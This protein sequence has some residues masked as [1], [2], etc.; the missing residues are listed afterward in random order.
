M[1]YYRPRPSEVKGCIHCGISFETNHKRAVYC[2]E[3][4]RQLAYQARH[5][6]DQ[7][8]PRKAKGDLDLSMQNVGVSAAGATVAA[9][10]NYFF[11]D[12]PAQQA[13]LSKLES[14]ER[15]TEQKLKQLSNAVQKMT[16][17][18]NVQMRRDPTLKM[19]VDQEKAVKYQQQ[20]EKDQ[21][22]QQMVT[23]LLAKRSQ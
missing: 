7:E 14:I 22:K 4:C 2:G 23:K 5:R 16:D 19:Q 10:G 20:V 3:S 11:N 13:I 1:G 8:K 6:L 9:A 21:R 12:R 15:G 18:V 17:Y